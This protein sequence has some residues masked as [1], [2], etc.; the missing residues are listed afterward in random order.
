VK[1]RNKVIPRVLAA[2][3]LDAE[4]EPGLPIVEL[5][6]DR[7]VLIENHLSV[8]GYTSQCICV[9]VKYGCVSIYGCELTIA[10]MSKDQLVILGDIGSIQLSREDRRK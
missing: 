9:R 6:G 4:L 1:P 8:I 5:A 2:A 3:D 7:R 10:K